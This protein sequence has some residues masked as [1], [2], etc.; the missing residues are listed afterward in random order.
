M[1]YLSIKRTVKG[2][3]VL[4]IG[5]VHK[6]VFPAYRLKVP[7]REIHLTFSSAIQSKYI[8]KHLCLVLVNIK[9]YISSFGKDYEL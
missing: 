3:P 2:Y 8:R 7:Q 1:T 6:N 4:N 5:R 9:L